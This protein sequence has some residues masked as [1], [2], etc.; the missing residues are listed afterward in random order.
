MIKADLRIKHLKLRNKLS[1]EEQER[2][3]TLIFERLITVAIEYDH[4]GVYISMP[5]E[6][7]TRKFIQW[8]FDHGKHVYV[9]KIVNYGMIF[10]EIHNLNECTIN[11]M[12][13]LEPITSI[14]STLPIELMVVP[15]LAYNQRNYRLGY[16]KG[17]YDQYLRQ[18]DEYKLGICFSMN[19]DNELREEEHDVKLAQI[20]TELK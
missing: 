8:C 12:G 7:D 18:H 1:V 20:F 9:P 6:V 4:I 3:S 5:Q 16:G 10:I 13:I 17:Y 15:M 14:E 2:F 11:K 19:F